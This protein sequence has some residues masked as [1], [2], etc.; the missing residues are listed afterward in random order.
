MNLLGRRRFLA[1]AAM[2]ALASPAR[3]GEAFA[4]IAAAYEREFGARVG[5]YAQSMRSGARLDHRPDERFALYSTAKASLAACT[6][7]RVD[8]G[9]DSLATLVPVTAADLLDHA[10]AARAAR[11]KGGMTVAEL[12]KGAVELSDNSCANLL[13]ARIGGPGALT[14]FWRETGDGLSRLDHVEPDLNRTFPGERH[15]TTTPRAMAG[16]LSRLVL[17]EVL[18]PASRDLLTEWLLNCQTGANRLRGGL[19]PDWRVG[20][21]TGGN[22]QDGA[23]DIAVIWPHSGGALVVAAYVQG[24][25]PTPEAVT[26]L[27]SAIGTAAAGIARD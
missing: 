5:L 21:K 23:G 27:F 11:A 17:G 7:A 20:N 13:L 12:C 8:R 1:A 6:L 26:R 15:D 24:G 19:P 25:R 22:G 9:Q 3:A 2:A 14:R 4:E 18:R 16:T 10:P